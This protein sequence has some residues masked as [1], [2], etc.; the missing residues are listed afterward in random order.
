VDA[1]GKLTP[2]FPNSQ[3]SSKTN[4][5][6]PGAFY[7][8]PESGKWFFL[9]ENKGR[10]Q[11]FLLAQKVPLSDPIATAKDV[12]TGKI[13]TNQNR[14]LGGIRK[15]PPTAVQQKSAPAVSLGSQIFVLKRYFIH[16]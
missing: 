6:I 14:G 3:I 12:I 9:D 4:P 8:V 5:V 15:N 7:R 10:E 16:Q 11:V 1:T 13:S 2:I